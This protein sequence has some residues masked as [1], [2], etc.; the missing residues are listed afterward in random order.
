VT[1]VL[2]I[3][4]GLHGALALLIDGRLDAVADMPFIKTRV[5]GE[6]SEGHL[7]QLVR[8]MS[9]DVAWI[10]RVSA[11]P[12]QGIASAFNFGTSY[13]IPRGV[14]AALGVPIF[15]V[16]P[17]EWKREFRLRAD[18]Q[19]SR[20]MASRMWPDMAVHFSRI[21]D[22]GRAEAALIAAFGGRYPL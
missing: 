1:R 15:L 6:I 9:P 19:Q 12:K 21:R 20:V 7:A 10:E 18:K 4:V 5:R 13:G 11:M 3:D 17:A 16:S 2:G 8:S 22:D 14:C